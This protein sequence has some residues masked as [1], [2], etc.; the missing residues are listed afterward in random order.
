[1]NISKCFEA[2]VA[3]ASHDTRAIQGVIAEV[4]HNQ[5]SDI[6]SKMINV[7]DISRQIDL[8]KMDNST[9]HGRMVNTGY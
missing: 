2:F 3:F 6:D 5:L 4:V 1:V 8:A 7:T 9:L